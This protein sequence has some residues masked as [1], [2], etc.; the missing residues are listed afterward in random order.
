MERINTHKLAALCQRMP[1][2]IYVA[3][4]IDDELVY[5][6]L[7]KGELAERLREM[8]GRKTVECEL[9]LTGLIIYGW[10]N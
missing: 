3:L 9:T 8:D 7:V 10:A 1:V 6:R 5:L 4:N 2:A